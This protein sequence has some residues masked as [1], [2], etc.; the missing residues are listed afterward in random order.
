MRRVAFV[1]S[2]TVVVY[3]AGLAAPAR[4]GL[5]FESATTAVTG[6]A[7]NYSFIDNDSSFFSGVNFFLAS[8][9]KVSDIGGHFI[10]PFVNGNNEIF[11]AIVRVNGPT[12]PPS[13]FD[14]SGP[15]VLG[16]TLIKL[17]PVANDSENESGALSLALTP[18][19]YAVI[20]GSGKFGATAEGSG[21]IV[22]SDGLP[23]NTNGVNT[24]SLRQSDGLQ[25]IQAAGARYFVDG[26]LTANAVPEPS[27]AYLLLIGLGALAVVSGR[28]F[29]RQSEF[30]PAS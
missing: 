1:G 2:L 7:S 16:T 23:A 8:P 27:S 29:R 17:P 15:D 12:D 5:L 22:V 30:Q 24:Y 4:A 18:G 6:P 11:G 3:F 20:F 26:E 14:L 25:I 21:A 10:T 13:P 9:A 28:S 19:W